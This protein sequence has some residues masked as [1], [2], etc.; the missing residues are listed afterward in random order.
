MH[1]K[2]LYE[3]LS[4]STQE[5]PNGQRGCV[6]WC[7]SKCL[8]YQWWTPSFDGRGKPTFWLHQLL[9]NHNKYICNSVDIIYWRDAKDHKLKVYHLNQEC[10]LVAKIA[11]AVAAQEIPTTIFPFSSSTPALHVHHINNQHCTV[12]CLQ[13]CTMQY[14]S[15]LLTVLLQAFFFWPHTS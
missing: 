14:N 9:I 4:S 11:K 3:S 2:K 13:Y 5:I 15:S 8:T 10:Y 7:M 6:D 12:S 1:H